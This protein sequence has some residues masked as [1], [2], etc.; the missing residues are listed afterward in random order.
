MCSINT[1]SH[2]S[3]ISPIRVMNDSIYHSNAMC[4]LV[5]NRNDVILCGESRRIRLVSGPSCTLFIAQIRH[6]TK[7]PHVFC[8]GDPHRAVPLRAAPH[9]DQ[10]LVV[11][12]MH[13]IV[14]LCG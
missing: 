7:F 14:I 3:A 11:I 8:Y 5:I 4:L 9:V 1:W 13:D 12:E 10:G 2:L 6:I